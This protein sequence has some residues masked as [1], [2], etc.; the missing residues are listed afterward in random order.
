[1]DIEIILPNKTDTDCFYLSLTRESGKVFI[2]KPDGEGGSFPLDVVTHILYEA[3]NEY[4]K[5]HF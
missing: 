4:Y 5:E 3:I 1:M 2:S